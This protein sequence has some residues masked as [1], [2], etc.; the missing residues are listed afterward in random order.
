MSCSDGRQ[1]YMTS[2]V[3]RAQ[4]LPR[5][6][7]HTLMSCRGPV[8]LKLSVFF[9]ITCLATHLFHISLFLLFSPYNFNSSFFFLFYF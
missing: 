3:D 1:Q 4:S 9:V 2:L 8:T 6:G 5:G 7:S